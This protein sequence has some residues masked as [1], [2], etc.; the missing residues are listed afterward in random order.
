MPALP[1]A[2]QAY[3][4]NLKMCR[5]EAQVAPLV[6]LISVEQTAGNPGTLG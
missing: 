5:G 2:V 3:A 6:S 1:I 4:L